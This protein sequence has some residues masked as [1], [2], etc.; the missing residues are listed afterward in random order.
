M[1]DA[2]QPYLVMSSPQQFRG[3][4][5]IE[6]TDVDAVPYGEIAELPRFELF[7]A[8]RDA[9]RNAPDRSP[10]RRKVRVVRRP[11]GLVALLISSAVAAALTIAGLSA[12]STFVPEWVIERAKNAVRAAQAQVQSSP[13]AQPSPQRG[14]VYVVRPGDTLS[15]IAART[16]G[17]PRKWP[18]LLEANRAIIH[19]AADLEIGMQ[20]R[21]PGR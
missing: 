3:D 5:I 21:L 18:R 8:G 13:R 20:L 19:N 4:R 10:P 6:S 14:T 16:L 17:D 15:L 9:G 12:V 2:S 11:P 1:S 7:D